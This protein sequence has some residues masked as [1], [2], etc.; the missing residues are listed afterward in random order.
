MCGCWRLRGDADLA[1]EPFGAKAAAS[2][3]CRT[4]MATGRSCFDILG[5]I[6]GRHAAAAD[7]LLQRVL[8]SDRSLE[9]VQ[10][11]R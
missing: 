10:R 1:A 5:Q 11:V 8:R 4:L 2:S 7:L 3:A 9:L 6:D